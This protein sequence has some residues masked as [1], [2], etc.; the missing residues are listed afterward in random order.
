MAGIVR[1]Q[2]ATVNSCKKVSTRGRAYFADYMSPSNPFASGIIIPGCTRYL[3]FALIIV[4]LFVSSRVEC[5]GINRK[6]RGRSFCCSILVIKKLKCHLFIGHSSRSDMPCDKN[7]IRPFPS[8]LGTSKKTIIISPQ[9]SSRP[10]QTPVYSPRRLLLRDRPT[11]FCCLCG[12][13][14]H[15]SLA[16]SACLLGS[17]ISKDT[18]LILDELGV[19]YCSSPL[20]V[21]LILTR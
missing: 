4:E 18:Q 5:S 1:H 9:G 20:I 21:Q 16:S 17:F 7:V 12:K 13:R 15:A 6:E 14:E 19:F 3:R 11:V 8:K 10:Q 2:Q